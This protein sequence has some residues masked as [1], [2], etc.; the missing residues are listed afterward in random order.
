[1]EGVLQKL[2]SLLFLLTILSVVVVPVGGGVG[3]IL[4]ALLTGRRLSAPGPKGATPNRLLHVLLGVAGFISG[5]V[6]CALT[7]SSDT[8]YFVNGRLTQRETTGLGPYI[9]YVSVAGAIVFVLGG[10]C[11]FLGSRS[12]RRRLK[13]T[14]GSHDERKTPPGAIFP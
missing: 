11:L 7:P 10:H 1:M 14:R 6:L 5:A 9:W 8:Q 3:W 13:G 2:S 4:G 12:L